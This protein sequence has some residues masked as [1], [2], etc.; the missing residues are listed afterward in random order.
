MT[1]VLFPYYL[2]YQRAENK[3]V[4]DADL[5]VMSKHFSIQ[6]GGA[7]LLIYALINNRYYRNI[8]YSRISTSY[9]W[10]RVILRQERTFFPCKNIGPGVYPAH[11]YSTILHAQSIGSNFSFRQ[12]T[13]I[14]NKRDGSNEDLPII[15]NNVTVGANVCIIGSI[16]I[17][18]N[19]Q[20]GAGSVV[21]KD[22]PS[23]SIAVGNPARV[24]KSIDN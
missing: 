12:C 5:A 10:L 6:L 1:V 3:E 16:S 8:F 23:N 4:I 2:A 19:V 7:R 18:D 17:G 24:I 11:P 14:G 13:T 22:I 9:R 20:I 21:V 15:G